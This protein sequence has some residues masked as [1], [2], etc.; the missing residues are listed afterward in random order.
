[1][2]FCFEIKVI[3]N[4]QGLPCYAT[5]AVPSLPGLCITTGRREK[6]EPAI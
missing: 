6:S 1:M 5:P 4:P 3:N 2:Q